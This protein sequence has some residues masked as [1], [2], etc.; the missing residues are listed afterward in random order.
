MTLEKLQQLFPTATAETWHRHANG[1]GWVQNTARVGPSVV[2]GTDCIVSGDAAVS[3]DARVYGDAWVISPLQ[4]AGTKHFVNVCAEGLVQIGCMAHDI[5]WWK[6]HCRAVGRKEGY[7]A[8]QIAEYRNYIE[9]ARVWTKIHG[10]D[11]PVEK[12]SAA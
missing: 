9:L 6:Q 3:G 5:D 1:G 11:K 10:L 4:I 2:I 12:E 7:S 8:K